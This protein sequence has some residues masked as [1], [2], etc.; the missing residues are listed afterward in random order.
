MDTLRELT[1]NLPITLPEL[2]VVQGKSGEVPV[3]EYDVDNGVSIGIDLFHNEQIAVQRT[4]CSGGSRFPRHYHKDV[5][6]F[7]IVYSGK[8][9]VVEPEDQAQ[10]LQPGD[11]IH[12]PPGTPH[13][14]EIVENTWILGI[15]V[16][17]AEG[18][19]GV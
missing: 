18:Y 2:V 5:H 6:E 16:P 8:V 1:H 7:L 11:W 4:F 17:A 3:I 13:R 14:L 12:F 9:D 19:P 15:T 10:T